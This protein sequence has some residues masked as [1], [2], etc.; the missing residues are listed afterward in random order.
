MPNSSAPD[1]VPRDALRA[2]FEENED[3][4]A[5]REAISEWRG[6]DSGTPLAA[7]FDEIR[8]GNGPKAP[9]WTNV[10]YAASGRTAWTGGKSWPMA[11][12]GS[13]SAGSA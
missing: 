10:L 11:R 2:L 8:R 1:E 12:P 7:A 5:V 4:H 3:M 6:G 9:S 13:I